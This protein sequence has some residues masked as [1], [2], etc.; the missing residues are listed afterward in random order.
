M[1]NLNFNISWP[2]K[3]ISRRDYIEKS[4][5]LSK[6]KSVE[7]QL[8]RGG[9]SLL[10]INIRL[11]IYGADHAGLK[12]ELEFMRHFLIVDLYDNRH[13]DYENH[14]WEKNR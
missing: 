1:I 12:F 11:D 5:K 10:G 14:C 8:S 4:W 7:V 2:F 3:E 13:W 6:N 9:N